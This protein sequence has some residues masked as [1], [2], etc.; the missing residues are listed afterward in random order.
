MQLQVGTDIERIERF[1]ALVQKEHFLRRVFT[2]A[3]QQYL[4]SKQARAPQTAAGLFCAKEAAAKALGEGLY[5]LKPCEIEVFHD[6]KGA[7]ALRLL[8]EAAARYGH[9]SFSLSISHSG[10]FAIAVCA[11]FCA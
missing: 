10:D 1:V 3:E 2:D 7:P 6:D 5:G 11:A 4:Q 9:F 8:G